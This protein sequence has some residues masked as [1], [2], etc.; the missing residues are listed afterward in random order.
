MR[1]S[2]T[3]ESANIHS[4]G[5]PVLG[6]G[7]KED[8]EAVDILGSRTAVDVDVAG[9]AGLVHGVADEEGAL[10]GVEAGARQAAHGV[11]GGGGALGVALEDEALVRVGP[12]GGRD[13]VDD[14]GG[15]QGRVLARVGQV[16]RVVDLAAGHLGR[17]P[18]V[19]G[20]EAA[21]LALHLARAA[22]VDDGVGAAG[23]GALVDGRLGGG[24]GVGTQGQDR[25]QGEKGVGV[26][27]GR[28]GF[29]FFER[30]AREWKGRGGNQKSG[31][32]RY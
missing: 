24:G 12:Q 25:D 23:A 5:N 28:R 29:F 20:D 14:V 22:R 16:D 2:R 17:Q 4:L 9:Q 19:D 30:R 18:A 10:D 13:L 15:A 26:H 6:D 32:I 7:A 27:G 1:K 11:D 8:G 3:Y 31:M 21:G